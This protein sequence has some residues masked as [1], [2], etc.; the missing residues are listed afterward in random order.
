MSIKIETKTDTAPNVTEFTLF[1]YGDQFKEKLLAACKI[2][3]YALVTV[4]TRIKAGVGV[5]QTL[6]LPAESARSVRLYSSDESIAFV[7]KR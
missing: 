2:E 6:G 1:V 3:L 7:P 5:L 4:Y